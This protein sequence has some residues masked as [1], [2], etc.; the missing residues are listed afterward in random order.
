MPKATQDNVIGAEQMIASIMFSTAVY[1]CEV[2]HGEWEDYHGEQIPSF[3]R[4]MCPFR[5]EGLRIYS[6]AYLAKAIRCCLKDLG[7]RGGF[8][9]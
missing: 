8:Q 6:A 5:E 7:G 4:R 3:M 9:I 1:P 2:Q